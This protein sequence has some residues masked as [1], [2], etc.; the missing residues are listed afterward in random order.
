MKTSIYLSFLLALLAAG[1]GANEIVYT[2]VNPSFGGSP[3]NGPV[4]LNSANAQNKHTD[5]ALNSA[6]SR[7]GTQSQL[8]LF[9]Q[10]LQSLILDRIANSLTGS[11][12]DANG[13]LKPGTVDTGTFSVTIVDQ[14]GGLLLITTTDKTTGASTTFQVSTAP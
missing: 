12:F 1:A 3:L 4:L 10:R 9:N 11:I 5:P 13:N 8:D 2:P 6:L 14:G 7:F